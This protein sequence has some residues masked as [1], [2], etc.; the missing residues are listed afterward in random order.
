MPLNASSG[1]VPTKSFLP[2]SMEASDESI[3]NVGMVPV[4]ALFFS[5]TTSKA[6]KSPNCDGMFPTRRFEGSCK[7]RKFD[8]RNMESGKVPSMLLLFK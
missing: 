5:D 2:K 7:R 1:M 8:K 4:N 6:C 3:P